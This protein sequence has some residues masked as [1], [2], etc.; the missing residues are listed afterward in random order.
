MVKLYRVIV[1]VIVLGILLVPNEKVI[2]ETSVNDNG[3]ELEDDG[4]I[5]P[6][7]YR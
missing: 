1:L 5:L 2:A 3:T 4:P 7:E 6:P